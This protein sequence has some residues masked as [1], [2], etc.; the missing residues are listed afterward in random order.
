MKTSINF[1]FIVFC[2][3]AKLKQ[4]NEKQK[5]TS[6]LSFSV[7]AELKQFCFSFIVIVQK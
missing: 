1:R 6:V 7:F 3:F 4:I 5:S 2:F